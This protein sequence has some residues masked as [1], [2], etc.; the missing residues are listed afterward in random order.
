MVFC[1]METFSQNRLGGLDKRLS[2]EDQEKAAEI[3]RDLGIIMYASFIVDPDFTR[4][5]FKALRAYIRRLKLKHISF[6]ILTPL[7]RTKLFEDRKDELLTD[8]FELFDLL[9]TLLPTRLPLKEFYAEFASLYKD[10]IPLHRS[11]PVLALYGLRRIPE[12]LR[13]VG[14]VIDRIQAS[15]LDHGPETMG[16]CRDY[17]G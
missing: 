9:H 7:P 12:Q 1:G 3:L 2:I 8:R 17:K 4:K 11:L 15:Y 16:A 10:A 13:L 5:D 14:P 6:S